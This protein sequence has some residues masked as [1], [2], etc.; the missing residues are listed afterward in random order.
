MSVTCI[1][2]LSIINVY[3]RLSVNTYN[4]SLALRA[5]DSALDNYCV[6]KLFTS[7]RVARKCHSIRIHAL[8]IGI[9]VIV[10]TESANMNVIYRA[11]DV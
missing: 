2:I 6:L 3:Q 9:G 8:Y 7:F 4:T 10:F 5:I 1:L 11:M